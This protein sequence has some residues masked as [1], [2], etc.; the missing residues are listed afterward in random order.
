MPD[1]CP[2]CGCTFWLPFD[3]KDISCLRCGNVEYG[4]ANNDDLHANLMEQA[5]GGHHGP[6]CRCKE[7]M[8]FRYEAEVDRQRELLT[9]GRMR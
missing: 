1:P 7:C 9:K 6:N 4:G 8:F 2:R 5:P 3:G